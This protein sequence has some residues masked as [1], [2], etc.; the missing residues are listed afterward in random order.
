MYRA[1]VG[2][3]S[4]GKSWVGAYDLIRRARRDR[5]YMVVG[6]TYT[7]L[8][9]SSLKSFLTVAREIGV[10]DPSALKL[11]APP[12]LRLTTGATV[13]FRSADNPELLRGP[14]LSGVW[15]DEASLMP[16]LAYEVGIGRL[17]E[18]GEQGWLSATFTPK[19]PSHW[20]YAIF[21]EGGADTEL[22][23]A[24]TA[25]NPFNPP[26][27]AARLRREYTNAGF[28]RQELDGEFVQPEG[29]VFPADWLTWPGFFVDGPPDPGGVAHALLYLDPSW[30]K[31]GKTGDQQAFVVARFVP[32]SRHE[33]LIYL[34]CVAVKE[35]V[36]AMVTR[37]V[38]LCRSYGIRHVDYEVNGTMG[39]LDAEVRRQ[40]AAALMPH[41]R[42]C[43]VENR[44]NKQERITNAFLPYLKNRQIRIIDSPGGRLLKA[45][46][47]DTPFAVSD[48]C[49]DAGAGALAGIERLLMYGA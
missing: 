23:T 8:R 33:N 39:L 12:E 3:I 18:H 20:T 36:L 45:Q 41:V 29:A 27:F 34:E 16:R 46:L 6:P 9:D 30:G 22:I 5:T 4:T 38:N 37:A 31:Q 43:P 2:G 25:D 26:G 10:I 24:R 35:D 17:R 11:G 21:K 48:D 13:L 19:G 1:F 7:S 14:N 44:T 49:A 28:A 47:S 32:G 42:T 40:L 15:L